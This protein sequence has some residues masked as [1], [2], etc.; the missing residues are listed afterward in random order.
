[1]PSKK[2]LQTILREQYGIN[3]NIS[4][5]LATEDCEQLLVTLQSQP[6]AVKIV[7]SFAEKNADLGKRNQ[8]FGRLRSNAEAK[9]RSLE[10]DYQ[11]LEVQVADME[12]AKDSLIDRKH[13]IATETKDLEAELK[14]L[15][16][17][18]QSL[19]SRVKLLTNENS[20]LTDAN[21]ELKKDNKN[22]KNL[23]DQIRLRLA[24]DTKMLLQYEDNE[25]R[26]AM[27]RLFRWTLG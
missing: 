8:H 9:L 21:T 14:R 13:L 11:Q 25:I 18:K 6:S 27:I 17:E 2:E 20:E 16:D 19:N 7:D 22:L 10:A 15:Q 26:K 23:V 3:K 24:H 12:R 1:M 4:Q 5:A